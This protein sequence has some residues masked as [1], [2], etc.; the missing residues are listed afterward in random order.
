VN[1]TC[2]LTSGRLDYDGVLVGKADGVVSLDADLV[3]RVRVR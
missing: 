3:V 1:S 2:T